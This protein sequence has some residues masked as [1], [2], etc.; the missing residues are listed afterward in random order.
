VSRGNSAG[1]VQRESASAARPERD[2]LR[3]RELTALVQLAE[4]DR[5]LQAGHEQRLG[6]ERV[7]E[8]H[9]LSASL[10]LELRDAYERALRAGREPAV[11]PLAKS[12]CSGCHVRLHATLEQKVRARRGVAP[13]AH[14]LRLV[15][16]PAWLSA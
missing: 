16:D 6:E 12:V 13:C 5:G 1:V 10:S 15:Y 9:A 2:A 7:S 14:C 4:L 3:V 8:R 11:V